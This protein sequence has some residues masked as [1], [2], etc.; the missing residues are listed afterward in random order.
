MNLRHTCY[1]A[2][3]IML[4][5][6]GAPEADDPASAPAAA[7]QPVEP[8]KPSAA[9]LFAG[10][11]DDH[12]SLRLSEDPLLAEQLGKASGRGKLPDTSVEAYEAGVAARQA[13]LDRL[14]AIDGAALEGDMSINFRLLKRQLEGAVAE[15][16]T[17]GK[18]FTF[19]TYY[20]PVT[21]LTRVA[22]R[23]TFRKA[24]DVTS[25]ID[26]LRAMNPSLEASIRRLDEGVEMGWAQPCEALVG[27]ER[28]YRTHLV[29]NI[30][31]SVFFSPFQASDLP[32]S[33]Q[34]TEATSIIGTEIIPM[35]KA[36]GD[37]YE[38]RYTPNCRQTA[39][40]GSLDGG[41]AYYALQAKRYT[42]TD[43]TPDEIH[44]IGL[45]EVARIRAKMTDVAAQAGF[46]ALTSFQTHL[47]TSPEFYPKTAEER[48]AAAST[49][50][51]KMDGKLVELFS[52]LPRMPYDIRPIPLD[53]AEGTTTAYYSQ[54]AADGRRAG[55]YW[56]NTTRL[57]T[58]PLYELEALTLHEAVPGHHLQIALQQELDLPNFRRF[59]GFTA[60][61]EGWGL[62][63]ERL[64]LE[65]GFYDTPE[66][67]FGRLSYEMWRA[68]RLVVDTGIHAKGWTRQE[69]ID[70]ML[71]NT[72]LS[73]NNIE[74]EVDRYITWP[75][76]ALAYKIGELKIRELRAKA[77]D[78]LGEDLDLRAFHDA[79]L[80][81]G[82]LPL[83]V[84]EEVIDAWIAEE[85]Q[86]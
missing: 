4:A 50:A 47:R 41:D 14:N 11:L 66:T 58:R 85:K 62:Y 23:T 77:E 32:S 63:S 17:N 3:L 48:M 31:E 60:F 81:N 75:G 29:E 82:A 27:F 57:S 76:Q 67:N 43:L 68:C 24:E 59:G 20:A 52:I 86:Q 83:S 10:I 53:I 25:Y 1:A 13:L 55:T 40:V 73:Q 35:I 36:F 84:L 22:Q 70:F 44:Q 79:V 7:P 51:K 19:S 38:G 37:F 2:V 71:E 45:D 49:I 21:A 8:L 74:R 69:A 5:A 15:G 34:V 6:C 64:G 72:G 26:R 12:W 46:D 56:L 65:V 78:E 33:E 18:Y 80:R 54:P 39:G 28:T 16:A 61:T 9:D 42:T 30:D